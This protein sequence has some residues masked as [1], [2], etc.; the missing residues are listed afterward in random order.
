MGDGLR[1][2]AH[3]LI[4]LLEEPRRHTCRSSRKLAQRTPVD[5]RARLAAREKVGGPRRIV[6]RGGRAV[7]LRELPRGAGDLL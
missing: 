7:R 5:H 6:R 1:Q 4:A 3:R 2:I